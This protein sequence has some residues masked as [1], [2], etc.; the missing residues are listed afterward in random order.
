MQHKYNFQSYEV[1]ENVIFKM[2]LSLHELGYF[3]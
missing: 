3:F 1:K 2:C